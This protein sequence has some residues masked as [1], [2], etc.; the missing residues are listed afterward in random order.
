[1][2]Q[3]P[4][5]AAGRR[6]LAVG[7]E[8]GVT[9]PTAPSLQPCAAAE[10]AQ[11]W[12]LNASGYPQGTILSAADGLNS[13]T[14]TCLYVYGNPCPAGSGAVMWSCIK[15]G[16]PPNTKWRFHAGSGT[17]R[18]LAPAAAGQP[19]ALLCLSAPNLSIEPCDGS[20]GQRWRYDAAS[21]ALTVDIGASGGGERR[22]L[23]A[24]HSSSDAHSFRVW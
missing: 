22:C 21:K 15:A 8:G 3:D 9:H 13:S 14:G 16:A 6:W 2:N 5:G 20:A 7:E 12:T 11:Q 17:L 23:S 1:M 4:K 18:N 24:K 10:P 19:P